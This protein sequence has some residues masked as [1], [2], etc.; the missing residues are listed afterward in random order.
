MI[1]GGKEGVIRVCVGGGL[2]NKGKERRTDEGQEME[3]E[4]RKSERSK[5]AW[6]EKKLCTKVDL[7]FIR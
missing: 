7:R 4:N 3:T 5:F 6:M 1:Q 2:R